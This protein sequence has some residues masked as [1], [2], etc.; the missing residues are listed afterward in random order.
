MTILQL[1]GAVFV[2]LIL[3][4]TIIGLFGVWGIMK[5]ETAWK[6]FGTIVVVSIGLGTASVVITRFFQDPINQK[7]ETKK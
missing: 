7:I 5:P 3:I 2:V 6:C 4:A 1:V